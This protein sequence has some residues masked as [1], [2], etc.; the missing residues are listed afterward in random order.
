[1]VV[2]IVHAEIVEPVPLGKAVQPAL[3]WDLAAG[4]VL[5]GTN[6]HGLQFGECRAAGG[7]V[8]R[9][10]FVDQLPKEVRPLQHDAAARC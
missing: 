1:V 2:A 5:R 4:M 3:L 10:V 9:A 6:L 7:G 8:A